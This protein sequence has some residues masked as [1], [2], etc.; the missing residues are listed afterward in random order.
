MGA[1][2]RD[3]PVMCQCVNIVSKEFF[4]WNKPKMLLLFLQFINLL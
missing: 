2:I 3:A 1:T 4:T